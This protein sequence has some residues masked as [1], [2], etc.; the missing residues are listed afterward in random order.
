MLNEIRNCDEASHGSV[1]GWSLLAPAF[2]CSFSR[3]K[4]LAD[5]SFSSD[6][7]CCVKR[8]NP[9]LCGAALGVLG[10]SLRRLFEQL[11]SCSLNIPHVDQPCIEKREQSQAAPLLQEKGVYVGV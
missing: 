5:R 4:P 11:S 3:A 1:A 2:Q 7:R 8:V 10:R 6:I 9:G